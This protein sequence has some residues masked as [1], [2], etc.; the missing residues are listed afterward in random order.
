[1]ILTLSTNSTTI[2][3][4]STLVFSAVITDP[5]GV[6]D[7][8]GGVLIDAVT[9][10]TYG[11]FQTAASEGAYTLSLS[12]SAL[13]QVRPID[14]DAEP[15][16]DNL[17][18]FT[19]RF[20]DAEGATVER[21][22][23]IT[24]TCNGRAACDGTC[25]RSRCNGACLTDT[26]INDQH[27]GQCNN[28]CPSETRCRDVESG[29]EVV[30]ACTCPVGAGGFDICGAGEC[31]DFTTDADNCGGCGNECVSNACGFGAC[32]CTVGSR[33]NDVHGEGSCVRPESVGGDGR[34]IVVDTQTAAFVGG[35]GP[36]DGFLHLFINDQVVPT[37]ACKDDFSAQAGEVEE[38]AEYWCTKRFGV[39][40]H[41]FT[42]SVPFTASQSVDTHCFNFGDVNDPSFDSCFTRIFNPRTM[43]DDGIYITCNLASAPPESA[44]SC[45]EDT[46]A[47]VG[48][49]TGTTVGEDNTFNPTCGGSGG[50]D[51]VFRF[52]ASTTANYRFSTAGSSFSTILEVRQQCGGA[53]LACSFLD[54]DEV[55]VRLRANET[56]LV[57]VDGFQGA[58]GDYR[59]IADRL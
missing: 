20:F 1:M 11:A 33:C 55:T 26:F 57:V 58:T 56:V 50:A 25:G 36:R 42:A 43:C 24:L 21:T 47:L 3:D 5:D 4:T 35:A 38:A 18:V 23:Q 39:G 32:G 46:V 6:D 41:A 17:R 51:K 45:A 49:K 2:T 8:I 53:P 28:A 13:N 30:A 19:A 40:G 15:Q 9:Q 31:T 37:P 22:L 48:T 14:F 34:C 7:V 29:P 44:F 16:G 27:C 12:W 54:G 59:L 52:T 10:G